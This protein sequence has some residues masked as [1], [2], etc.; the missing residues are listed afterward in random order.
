MYIKLFVALAAMTIGA[1]AFA[2][3]ICVVNMEYG[4]MNVSDTSCGVKLIIESSCDG[5]AVAKSVYN[6][7][8][9]IIPRDYSQGNDT[10]SLPTTL[11]QESLALKPFMDQGYHVSTTDMS[12]IYLEKP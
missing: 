2:A 10:C 3:S 4:D 8:G 1:Q 9:K 6:L 5:G 12:R 7:G 11:Q